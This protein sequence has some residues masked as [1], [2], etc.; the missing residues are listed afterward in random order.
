M[1][2]DFCGFLFLGVTRES[3]WRAGELRSL[4]RINR[5]LQDYGDLGM[6][7]SWQSS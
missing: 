2:V 6:P 4:D 7:G 1:A 3:L 5:I